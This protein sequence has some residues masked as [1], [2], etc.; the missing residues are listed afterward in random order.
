MAN[1]SSAEKRI[2]QTERRTQVNRSR[3]SRIHTFSRKVE[4][5]IA[6]GDAAKARD[7]LNAF[8]P[9]LMRGVQKGLFHKNTA[10]RTMSRL[11]VRVKA[12][13]A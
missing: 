10:A 3:K 5:A 11:S 1:H 9:E 12:L 7:A 2:R 6:S 8:Q 13:A 4:E